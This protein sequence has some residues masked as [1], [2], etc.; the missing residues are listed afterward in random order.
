[1]PIRKRKQKNVVNSL[2][3]LVQAKLCWQELASFGPRARQQN[4]ENFLSF[5]DS[6]EV[7]KK[8][9]RKSAAGQPETD[10]NRL[11]VNG[12]ATNVIENVDNVIE[13]SQKNVANSL[14]YFLQR[15]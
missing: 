13:K 8:K 1:M 7:S 4:F 14:H 2:H 15:K 3:Y 12:F 5:D 9:P 6:L 11:N 10:R